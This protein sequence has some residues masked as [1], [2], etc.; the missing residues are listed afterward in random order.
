MHRLAPVVLVLA[1]AACTP[2]APTASTASTSPTTPKAS[3]SASPK[4][5]TS[6][7]GSAS[8]QASSAPTADG[9]TVNFEYPITVKKDGTTLNI[10]S[11]AQRV[12]NEAGKSVA[13]TFGHKDGFL[14]VGEYQLKF[15]YLGKEKSPTADGFQ[16]SDST[17]LTVTLYEGTGSLPKR[18]VGKPRVEPTT[19][20]LAIA[21]GK[22][23][24][25]FNGELV[26]YPGINPD[27][28]F[29]VEFELA[30]VPLK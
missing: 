29:V 28:S 25:S 23:D 9:A 24:F 7:S 8:P 18:Y 15:G 22:L 5:S 10:S 17:M 16:T 3:T 1:V 11:A 14:A 13:I 12:V 6:P 26:P 20:T 2:G 4:A 19:K 27:P 21:D 30:D